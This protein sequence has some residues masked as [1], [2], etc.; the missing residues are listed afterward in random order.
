VG[1]KSCSAHNGVRRPIPEGSEIEVTIQV[2][3]SR[4][5]TAAAFVP[6]LNNTQRKALL[7]Q[8]EEQD[9]ADLSANASNDVQS[10]RERLEKLESTAEDEATQTNCGTSQGS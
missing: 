4:L 9:F 5:I 10:Y 2:D 7:P 1:R 6:H 8:R 3:S